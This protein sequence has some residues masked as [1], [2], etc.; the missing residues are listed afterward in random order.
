MVFNNVKL[1]LLTGFAL[2]ADA[3]KNKN[4]YGFRG[5]A[6]SNDELVKDNSDGFEADSFDR[7]KDSKRPDIDMPTDD[8]L[9]K[10]LKNGKKNK[11]KNKKNKSCNEKDF[12][13][14]VLYSMWEKLSNGD[15]MT[16]T[17]T[18]GELTEMWDALIG[19]DF[20]EGTKAF[21]SGFKFGDKHL[22]SEP[23]CREECRDAPFAEGCQSCCISYSHTVDWNC[24][25]TDD[26]NPPAK[27]CTEWSE[28]CYTTDSDKNNN[29]ACKDCGYGYGRGYGYG[30][31]SRGYGGYGRGG[32]GRR[33]EGEGERSRRG[34]G[35]GGY[36]RGYGGYGGYRRYGRRRSG[37]GYGR[38][39]RL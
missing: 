23:G 32:Y 13:K 22:W 19:E 2:M 37:A 6:D 29:H 15:D 11:K 4:K 33:L 27:C 30:G 34:Y 39:R 25:S 24:D 21:E 18:L 8:D 7:N 14:G 16:Q 28:E 10:R 36:G 35:Y 5:N 9:L 26:E 12:T 17:V 3:K 38:G 1:A 31:Y 20:E